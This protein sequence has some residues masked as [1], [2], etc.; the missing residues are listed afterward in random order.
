MTQN[1][2]PAPVPKKPGDDPLERC[3]SLFAA[4]AASAT[5]GSGVARSFTPNLTHHKTRLFHVPRRPSYYSLE[6]DRESFY[7]LDYPEDVAELARAQL[8]PHS[9]FFARKRPRTLN[10]PQLLPYETESPK[11]QA[12]FLSHIVSHLYIAIKTLDIQGSL[13]VTAKDLASV[14]ASLSDVDVALETNLFEFNADEGRSNPT[15][16]PQNDD[17]ANYFSMEELN[18][19]EDEEYTDDE[20]GDEGDNDDN[21]FEDGDEAA[22]HEQ[23]QQHKRSP[24]SAAIVGVR[25]WTHELL[26]WLKMKYEM[27]VKLRVLL[28]RVYYA[29]C[30][31][32]GQH[33]NLKTY[34]KTFEILTKDNILMREHGLKLAWQPLCTELLNHFPTVDSSNHEQYYE[35]KDQK[36]L[37][38]LAERASF[39]FDKCA[40]PQIYSRIGSLFSISTASLVLLSLALLPL[41]FTSSISDPE[42]IRHYVE[43]FFYLWTKLSKSTG[44]DVHLTSRLGTISMGAL[45]DLANTPHS[46]V[47]LGE[48]GIFSKNQMDYIFNT[49]M[50]SLSVMHD[51]YG[52][53]KST[54]FHGYASLIVFSMT[55]AAV[56]PNRLSMLTNA[57]ELYVHPSNSG[58]WSRPISKLVLS[59]VHQFHKR[60]NMETEEYGL[61]YGLADAH[62]I[63]AHDEVVNGF[64]N[65]ILP[66]IKIGIHAKYPKVL[67]DYLRSLHM[68]THIRPQ[69]VMESMLLDIYES[70]EGVNSTHRVTVALRTLEELSRYFAS[71]PVFRVHVTRIL[72]LLL[73]G[74]D[75]NDL[76]K[77]LLTL[78]VFASMAS[79]VPF[80]DLSDGLQDTSLAVQYTLEHLEI[81][82]HKL[83]L[84]DEVVDSLRDDVELELSALKSSTSAFKMIFTGLFDKIFIL[85][86]NLPDPSK[87]T[88]MEKHVSEGLPKYIYDVFESLSDDIFAVISNKM[89]GF[90]SENSFHTI[91]DIVAEICGAIVKR[92]PATYF[93]KFAH[94]LIDRIREDI[95]EN[96]AGVS[97]TGVEIVSRDQPLFWNLVIL[98]ECIGNASTHV[99]SMGCEL[100]ELSF[101]LM[102]KVKGPAVF[103]SSYMLNQ[104]LQ[105]TTKIR[106]NENRLISPQYVAKYGV[107]EKC[108]GGFSLDDERFKSENL[109]F[110]WFI[111]SRRELRFAVD[112]FSD[113]V[114]KT[115]GNITAIMKTVSGS[116]AD[117]PDRQRQDVDLS[118]DL[119]MN[120]LYLGY[121]I[122]GISFLLDPSFD[123]DIP[124][125]GQNQTQ[126]LQQ[127]LMLLNQIRQLRGGKS[128]GWND[129][130]SRFESI[131][132]NLQKIV[133]DLSNDTFQFDLGKNDDL[134]LY[135]HKR[136]SENNNDTEEQSKLLNADGS[137]NI[138]IDNGGVE[139][140]HI[141]PSGE[142]LSQVASSDSLNLMDAS[143]RQ[144]PGIDGIDVSTM[145]PGITFRDHKLYTSNYLFGDSIE[146][147]R[148]NELYLRVHKIRNSIGRSFHIVHKFLTSHF[149]DNTK[150]FKHFLY[151][152]NMWF[153]DV[154]RERLLD[155]SHA[156]ISFGYTSVLQNINKIKKPYSRL[157]IASRLE[158]YHLFRVVLHATSRTQTDLDKL[159]LEDVVKLCF[160]NYSAISKPAQSTLVDAM[161]RLNGSYNVLIRSSLKYLA[162]AIDDNDIP[163]IESGLNTFELRRIKNKIQN[164]YFNIEKYVELLQKCLLVDEAQVNGLAHK[165]FKG[166]YNNLTPPSSVCLIHDWNEID[167]IRPPDRFIDLEINIVNL[168]KESKR[169]LYFEKLAKFERSILLNEKSNGHWKSRSLNLNLLINLQLEL[170]M[171]VNEKFLGI[172][173]LEAS[174]DHPLISRLAIRGASTLIKKINTLEA[175]QHNV[176]NAYDF[177]FLPQKLSIISTEPVIKNDGS[178]VS[179]YESW[180]QEL[181]NTKDPLYFVD[182]KANSGWLFWGK[183]MVVVDA[184]VKV[185]CPTDSDALKLFGQHITKD[186]FL[187]IVKLW[188]ADNESNFAFQ[189]TDVLFTAT[190]VHLISSGYVPHMTF[191]DLISIIHTI[192]VPDEKP[193]HIIVCE[194][195]SGV[196]ISSKYVYH[197]SE[198]TQERDAFLTDFLGRIFEADLNPDNS[199]VWNIFSWWVTTSV[200]VRRFPKLID[201]CYTSFTIDKDSDSAFLISSR[202]NYIKS[203]IASVS[204]SYPDTN[205]ITSMCLDN[206][207]N[208]YQSIRDQVGSL[209]AI[210][211]FVYYTESLPSSEH[212]IEQCNRDEGALLLE[213]CK[214]NKMFKLVPHIF[215]RIGAARLKVA[216]LTPQE[217]LRTEYIYS[218][219]TI[220]TWLDQALVTSVAV[221][222]QVYVDE[223]FFP[224]LLELTSM[225]DVCQLGNIDPTT[226]F[227]RIS[228]ISYSTQMLE[229][230]IAMIEN[231]SS[232]GT[233][234][235]VQS[236]IMGEFTETFYFKNLFRFSKQQRLRIIELTNNLVYHKS[237]E[238]REAASSTLSGLMHISPPQEVEVLVEALVVKYSRDLDSVRNKYRKK[239]GGGYKNMTAEDTTVLHAATLGL[240][241]LIHAFPYMSPPP[242]WVP[243]LLTILANKCSGVPGVVSKTAKDILGKFKKNRQDTW[244]IDSKVFSEDQI[245]DLEG[246]LWKSYFI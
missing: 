32:R 185:P 86:E 103:A 177:A 113:H 213:S 18:D 165:L 29:I 173:A 195:I 201:R 192:Y 231:Y 98:N 233:L 162:K 93:K 240:G 72:S 76:E 167:T 126:T 95:E 54:F 161:K 5:A 180:R 81:L 69:L 206:I 42:D 217:I 136:V 26:V 75:S 178:V 186:W 214:D 149:K 79:F 28:A 218:V 169:K 94:H 124:K 101:F 97:R 242:K 221:L 160:S 237:V 92:D 139:G 13:A 141:R 239:S 243:E 2:L 84:K 232:A 122:S 168:A 53:L 99:V 7:N 121:G 152:L 104:I 203:F 130:E 190:L 51:K 182:S 102:D 16:N 58:E 118:D 230:I 90:I 89:F 170:E 45:S 241:A 132:E 9:R 153:S 146:S 110:S 123:E 55:G 138:D 125:L 70:L 164:D 159:L 100:K 227:K 228:Q 140:P 20:D 133:E 210:L 82:H 31:C 10:L 158:A 198:I 142:D 196:L 62:K 234:N 85:L 172:L 176:A 181:L 184:N 111:P 222:Y 134:Q 148:S 71:T 238:V 24:K 19:T 77:S 220:L 188:V 49:L 199:G 46:V 74:I 219:S 38:R 207:A 114:S 109:K 3:N 211:T 128:H 65:N 17:D 73:P 174:N 154:G 166:V 117:E 200:D 83:I 25:I 212:F 48:C 14:R 135:D 205:K 215:E 245:Q 147:R 61:L 6:L 171:P 191:G 236:F 119:R 194:L 52:S 175:Y 145:N 37:L 27:P 47:R 151:A 105:A 209:L 57:I 131:H 60:Y 15:S 36:Q 12:K 156:R 216:D 223:Y 23:T 11:D 67:D 66:L 150:L 202:L 224:F 22:G 115:L 112:M 64:V 183:S 91:S 21:N 189:G 187:S 96:G 56:I 30:L 43:P 179:F 226:A 88:G 33:I 246:V 244:H 208:R 197:D 127:R 87:S 41:S 235:V 137:N 225:K 35:K 204:W 108:W 157:A 80:Q 107:N 8:D 106:L 68:L 59:L 34:V 116:Q 143:A 155:Y 120:F 229:R 63:S 193:S 1:A 39:F 129:D 50:N 4:E 78:N 44:I 144:S 40:L 163:K